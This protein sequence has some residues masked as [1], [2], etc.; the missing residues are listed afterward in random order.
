MTLKGGGGKTKDL[1]DDIGVR[2]SIRPAAHNANVNGEIVDFE[3][4]CLAP[5]GICVHLDGLCCDHGPIL[6][7]R[8]AVTIEFTL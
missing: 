4:R 6:P 5:I 1:V 2:E 7:Y 8:R 3:R